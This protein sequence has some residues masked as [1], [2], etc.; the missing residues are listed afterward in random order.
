MHLPKHCP[1]R[2]DKKKSRPPAKDSDEGKR[3]ISKGWGTRSGREDAVGRNHGLRQSLHGPRL[4]HFGGNFARKA[5]DV[6]GGDD[7]MTDES[8]VELTSEAH[9]KDEK[10]QAERPVA[11]DV[12]RDTSE[13]EYEEKPKHSLFDE[14]VVLPIKETRRKSRAK[15]KGNFHDSALEALDNGRGKPIVNSSFISVETL[16][17]DVAK[18]QQ[19]SSSE[20]F[21]FSSEGFTDDIG[22]K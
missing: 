4:D 5:S 8:D 3:K 13:Q 16:D 9:C 19:V 22:S 2:N 7:V 11:E 20:S 1:H 15:D 18:T 21:R 17:G 12:L 6:L 10:L 14:I